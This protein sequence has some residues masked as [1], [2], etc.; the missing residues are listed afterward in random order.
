MTKK[1]S[2]VTVKQRDFLFDNYR[3]LLILLV[4]AGHFVETIYRNNWMLEGLKWLIYSFHVPAFVFI[5]G[6]FSKKKTAFLALCR[7]IAVPYLVFEVLY[8]LLYTYVT[9]KETQLYL[10]HPKFTLWYLMALFFW[11]AATPYFKKIPGYFALSLLLGFAIGFSPMKDNYL[12]IPRALV[13]YPYFLAGSC[14]EKDTVNK[15]RSK[16]IGK[17]KL[18]SLCSIV[19]AIISI[20]VLLFAYKF[21]GSPQ[22]F[23]GR[24]SYATMKQAPAFGVAMRLLAYMIGF[25]VTYGLLAILPDK[26]YRFS[27]IGQRTLQVYLFHGLVYKTLEAF[28]L[29]SMVQTIPQTVLFLVFI[30]VLTIV[31]AAKPFTILLQLV[32]FDFAAIKK[33]LSKQS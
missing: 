28:G 9:H 33:T 4:V 3:T 13:F 5:S 15:I 26:E 21:P 8:Y 11:K 2:Q 1:A 10:M 18:S 17:V 22:I 20:C 6:Y 14:L 19:F 29:M 7:K 25:A 32:C 24:Y 12:T 30:I 16:Y 27:Y 23:Y 31:L